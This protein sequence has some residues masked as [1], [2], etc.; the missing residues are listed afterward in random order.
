[1][2]KHDMGSAIHKQGSEAIQETAQ[3]HTRITAMSKKANLH[4]LRYGAEIKDRSGL[5]R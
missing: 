5:W 2:V 4:M 1:M 3:G